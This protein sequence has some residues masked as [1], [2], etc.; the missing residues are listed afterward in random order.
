MDYLETEVDDVEDTHVKFNDKF[1]MYQRL[2]QKSSP[3]VGLESR[4]TKS[5]QGNNGVIRTTKCSAKPRTKITPMIKQ[6]QE[7]DSVVVEKKKTSESTPSSNTDRW[8]E[9]LNEILGEVC[10]RRDFLNKCSVERWTRDFIEEY[11]VKIPKGKEKLNLLLIY[12]IIMAC[13]LNGVFLDLHLLSIDLNVLLKCIIG[14]INENIPPITSTELS[15]RKLVEI[16]VS[17][18][19]ESLMSEYVCSMRRAVEE[20]STKEPVLVTSE[21]E[22]RY[23]ENCKSI[24]K[25]LESGVG[26]DYERQFCVTPEKVYIYGIFDV[27]REKNKSITE[28]TICDY[29]SSKF[30]IP[31]V[32][33][34]KIKRLVVKCRANR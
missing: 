30:C 33:V 17:L 9:R 5:S 28:R 16:M 6:R 15:H 8:T 27:I 32:T 12:C 2:I 11:K 4:I 14:A 23:S 7:G 21:D 25:M 19:R 29:L 1:H 13:R 31:R 20:F 3:Y 18:P 22:I 26:C 10:K 24:F 34:E